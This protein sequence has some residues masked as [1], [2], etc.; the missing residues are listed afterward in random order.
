MQ[1]TYV[2]KTLIAASSNGIGSV[3]TAATSVVTV[4]SSVLDTSRRIVFYSTA[5]ASSM[6]F[7]VFGY[8]SSLS[9]TLQSEVV[10]GSTASGLAATTTSDFYKVTSVTISTNANIPFLI[11]TS[12]VGGTPWQITD[13]HGSPSVIG[14]ALT[15]T[16]SA[17][18]MTGSIELTM[19][20]PTNTYPNPNLTVPGVIRSTSH[21]VAASTTS[22]GIANV[23]ANSFFPVSAWRMT[24]TSSS[25]AAGSLYGTV[26]VTGPS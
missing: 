15:F 12:S 14:A 5:D 22:F 18:G 3:S 4:N 21:V 23:D 25:S 11:G 20:D 8:G 24:L 16:T 19:D 7:T 2:S 26:I 13:W 1:P 17:N 6:D 10:I 9:A